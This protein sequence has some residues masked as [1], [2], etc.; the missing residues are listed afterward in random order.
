MSSGDSLA[1][2]IS[3]AAALVGGPGE[4]ARALLESVRRLTPYDAAAVTLF[5]PV[6][7]RQ[8]PLVRL[9]YPEKVQQYMTSVQFAVDVETVGLR[10]NAL[11]VRVADVPMPPETVPV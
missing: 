8:I 10:R 11:P 4:R 9:G 3:A 6:G 7:Q 5:D 1:A 2:Q